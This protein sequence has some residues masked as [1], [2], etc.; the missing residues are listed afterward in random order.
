MTKS[1][2]DKEA[3]KVAQECKEKKILYQEVKP[4]FAMPMLPIRVPV[5]VQAAP[6]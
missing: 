2:S 6:L 1:L 3:I 4:L 5:Q